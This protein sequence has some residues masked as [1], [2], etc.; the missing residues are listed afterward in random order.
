MGDM[1]DFWRNAKQHSQGKR[2][3]NVAYAHKR[4][5]ELGIKFE[6]KNYGQHLIVT[7]AHQTIDYWP[8]TGKWI[9]RGNDT[10]LEGKGRGIRGVIKR[11]QLINHGEDKP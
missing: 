7:G 2:A 6:A 5:T 9:A 8:S 10:H 3:T 1:G 4:L 11:C